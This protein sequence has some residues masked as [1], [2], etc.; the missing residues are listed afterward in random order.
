MDYILEIELFCKNNEFLYNTE[1]IPLIYRLRKLHTKGN[2]SIEIAIPHWIGVVQKAVLLYVQENFSEKMQN[3]FY[4]YILPI[5]YLPVSKELANY[6][7]EDIR[8]K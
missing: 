6:F 4:R 5:T 2:Y 7:D 1:I 3:V 8:E